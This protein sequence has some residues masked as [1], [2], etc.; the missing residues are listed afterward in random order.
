VHIEQRLAT[1]GLCRRVLALQYEWH[2]DRL[3]SGLRDRIVGRAFK[4]PA[5]GYVNGFLSLMYA[6][7]F[8]L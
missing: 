2:A 7:A 4:C 3:P 8:E 1:C 5:C 6:H